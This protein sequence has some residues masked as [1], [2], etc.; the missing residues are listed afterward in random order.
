[1]RYGVVV[2]ARTGMVDAAQTERTRAAM[3]ARGLPK[4]HR[5]S[6]CPVFADEVGRTH[7][8]EAQALQQALHLA[9]IVGLRCCT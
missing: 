1:M 3:R 5:F 4:D 9:G 2:D 7:D 6:S 8:P